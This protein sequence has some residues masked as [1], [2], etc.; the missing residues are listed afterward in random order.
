MKRKCFLGLLLS[1]AFVL[2]SA[3]SVSANTQEPVEDAPVQESAASS[4]DELMGS[5]SVEDSG[6]KEYPDYYGGSYIN[7]KGQFVVYV[8]DDTA[9]PAVLS[10]QEDIVYES[11]AYSYNELLAV[12]E[13]LNS[14]KFSCSNTIASN[15]NEFGLYDSINRVVVKLDELTEKRIQEFKENVSDSGAIIFEQGTGPASMEINVDPGASISSPLGTGSMGYRAKRDGVEGLVTAGHVI[16][17]GQNLSYNGTV[18]ASCVVS[19]QSGSADAAFCKITNSNYTPTN[20][21]SGTSNTLSTTISE[22]GVG[23]VINKIGQSTGHTSGS[24]L[25][26]NVT[27]TFTSGNTISNLTS[28]NY[29]SAAGDSGGIVYSYISATNTRLTLGIHTGSDGSTRYF[30]KANQANAALGTSRY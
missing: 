1:A 16:S 3:L 10:D 21:L 25:A 2:G 14:Y 20:T 18:F 26:I 4:Y 24:V 11:C 8:T 22:P 6:E 23:T 12:M 7:D 19:Q 29:T 27:V 30:T 13:V 15:F 17:S 9:R 28:A 5:F